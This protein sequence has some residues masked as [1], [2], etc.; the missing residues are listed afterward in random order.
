MSRGRR[1]DDDLCVRC[2][3]C[4]ELTAVG[5]AVTFLFHFHSILWFPA[6]ERSGALY[7]AATLCADPTRDGA[8][9]SGVVWRGA[10]ARHPLCSRDRGVLRPAAILRA[11]AATSCE[12]M[13]VV[14]QLVAIHEAAA[15]TS[16]A[17][18]HT[19]VTPRE[20]LKEAA[21]RGTVR[22]RR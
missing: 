12:T 9:W 5:I 1:N 21:A 10:Q 13:P 15:R 11:E 14:T 19:A 4:D 3:R 22:A 16:V 7:Y 6:T 8:R 17:A 20:L 2:M 18:S